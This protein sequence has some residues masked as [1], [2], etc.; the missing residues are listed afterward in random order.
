MYPFM[1]EILIIGKGNHA[2]V[3]LDAIEPSKSIKSSYQVD[4]YSPDFSELNN[5]NQLAFIAIGNNEVRERISKMDF[6]FGL[7]IVHPA[8]V[9]TISHKCGKGIYFGAN[10]FIGANSTVGNF[11]I[12]NTGV[13]LEHDCKVGEFSHLAPAVVTGGRV[14]IGSRTFIGMNSTIKNGVT[15]G[16]NCIIGQASNVICDIPDNTVWIGNPATYNERLTKELI[17]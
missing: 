2:G 10:S 5:P 4:E 13:I 15:I 14:K 3:I 11:T 1:N 17:K 9:K 7:N 6:N 8:A 16:N 12:I